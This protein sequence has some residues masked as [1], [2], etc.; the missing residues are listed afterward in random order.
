MT[1]L[2]IYYE[3]PQWFAPL[4]DAL[5]RRG[6]GYSAHTL[7]DHVFDPADRSLPAPVCSTG[8]R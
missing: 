3:H 8:W 6:V 5:D 4:F 2:A 1:D 7:Q